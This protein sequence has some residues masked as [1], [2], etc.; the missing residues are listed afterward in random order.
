M[1]AKTVK[2]FIRNSFYTGKFRDNI[3]VIKMGGNII[4]S[5]DALKTLISDIKDITFGGVRVLLVYGGGKP[6][7]DALASEGIVPNKIEGR[8]VTSPQDLK[9]IQRVLAGDLGFSLYSTMAQVGLHGLLLNA[10][11]HE[12]TTV[13]MRPK[14]PIDLGLA[15][16]IQD[17]HVQPIHDLFRHTQFVATPCLAVCD[18]GRGTVVNINADTVATE[19]AI[20]LKAHKLIFLTDV[21]GVMVNGAVTSV[22]SD[23]DA[24]KLIA[25]GTAL[26]GM[27]IKLESCLKAL[28]KGVKRIHIINGLNPDSLN[29]EIFTSG[30][31]GTMLLRETER[32]AYETEIQYQKAM[33]AGT[34]K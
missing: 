18:D 24:T 31:S 13:A 12:W 33:T 1:I 27:K 23:Q 34:G 32:P 6:I 20:G 10:L 3:F 11:P 25:N 19:L 29:K 7:D 22:L 26:G 28:S 16:I 2:N 15:G 4:S 8:R 5:P 17:V 21:D 9:I 30:G 14:E